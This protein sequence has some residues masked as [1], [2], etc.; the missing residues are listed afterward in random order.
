[1]EDDMDACSLPTVKMVVKGQP[2]TY[3]CVDYLKLCAM[4]RQYQ[5]ADRLD[6]ASSPQVDGYFKYTPVMTIDLL[7]QPSQD[8]LNAVGMLLTALSNGDGIDVNG[9]VFQGMVVADRISCIE[10]LHWLDLADPYQ[11]QLSQ[12]TSAIND[13]ILCVIMDATKDATQEAGPSSSTS[14]DPNV[15]KIRYDTDIWFGPCKQQEDR[16]T[17]SPAKKAKTHDAANIPYVFVVRKDGANKSAYIVRC[18]DGQRL[19][20]SLVAVVIEKSRALSGYGEMSV[21]I[22]EQLANFVARN[23]DFLLPTYQDAVKYC[24][25]L[26][27]VGLFTHAY[28]LMTRAMRGLHC[29]DDGPRS[30]F[31]PRDNVTRSA[32]IVGAFCIS[33]MEPER[34]RVDVS[35]SGPC[36]L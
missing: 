6:R 15:F 3:C 20:E 12:L 9:D 1:M 19:R 31:T 36:P 2:S 35:Y 25:G 5:Q 26:K 17:I 34:T 16:A 32:D 21:P 27:G 4:S 29:A 11:A 33:I 18:A 28:D 10:V 30:R 8:A 22:V 23:V 7:K 14:E 13:D 24:D